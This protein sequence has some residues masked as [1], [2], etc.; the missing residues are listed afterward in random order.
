M[1]LFFSQKV[2]ALNL[3]TWGLLLRV[4]GYQISQIRKG[5]G[6]G[7]EPNLLDRIDGER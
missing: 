1:Y 6:G 3:G 7:S 2:V 4:T 5:I